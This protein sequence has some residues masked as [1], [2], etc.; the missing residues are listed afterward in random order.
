M[1]WTD[2]KSFKNDMYD[3]YVEHLLNNPGVRNTQLDRI[4][5]DG[6]YSKSNCR[7]VTAKENGRNKRNNRI[8]RYEGVEYCLK[9]FCEVYNLPYKN[10][11]KRLFVR[12]W[13][14]EKII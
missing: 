11:W 5:N 4:N 9:E 12:N 3:S 2:Y 10:T 7:W 14:I 8:I 6:N 1:G 13:P